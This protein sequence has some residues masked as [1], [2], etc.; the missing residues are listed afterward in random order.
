M[1]SIRPKIIVDKKYEPQTKYTLPLDLPTTGR[2]STLFLKVA[3]KTLT[4]GDCPSPWLKYL[5]SSISVNQAGQ[6]ALNA[7][8]PEVFQ[9]DYYYKTGNMPQRGYQRPGGDPTLIEEVIPILFGE[10]EDDMEHYIDLATLDDPKLS[11]AYDLAETDHAASTIWDTSYY[12][13][14]SVIANLLEGPEIPASLGYYSLRQI[15]GYTPGNS[16]KKYVELKSGRPIKRLYIQYDALDCNEEL[17]HLVDRV[18]VWG[19][20]EAYIP[21]DLEIWPFEELI[22]TL[23]G[24]CETMCVVPYMKGGQTMDIVIG[25]SLGCSVQ[26]AQTNDR[27]AV[28]R[29]ASGRRATFILFATSGGTTSTDTVQGELTLKG[30]LPWSIAPIDMPKMIGLDHLDPTVHAPV[31]LELDHAVNAG[32]Y[33]APMKIHVED[34]VTP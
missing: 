11:V 8:P 7:A 14:F 19:A 29:D 18:R 4:T 25:K 26:I 33:S 27:T 30:L 15:E 23:Y 34:L 17:L 9:A 12:P 6:A 24:I 10:K 28:I 31:F 22:R 16:E 21:L 2:V 1:P 13:R 32:D 5:I 20:N 3:A